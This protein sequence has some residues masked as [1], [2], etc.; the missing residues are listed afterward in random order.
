[1]SKICLE[2]TPVRDEGEAA[3]ESR[4]PHPL[5]LDSG[6]GETP[7]AWRV[8]RLVSS[9]RQHRHVDPLY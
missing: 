2:L 7:A 5:T 4:D 8:S 1:M 9:F 6:R 3:L